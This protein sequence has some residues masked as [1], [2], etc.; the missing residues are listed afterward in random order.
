MAN[1]A[2]VPRVTP[3]DACAVD[4][5]PEKCPIVA[6]LA[7]RVGFK[8]DCGQRVAVSRTVEPVGANGTFPPG[9]VAA[10]S[11][12]A[13]RGV[14]EGSFVGAAWLAG[15]RAWGVAELA[16]GTRQALCQSFNRVGSSGAQS[17]ALGGRQAF[18]AAPR[19]RRAHAARGRTW[20]VA[21]LA[22]GAE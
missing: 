3:A 22:D 7:P 16:D 10:F 11:A 13:R 8:A 5:A 20:G 14:C 17:G 19:S 15:G 2:I 12:N 1:Q 4:W 9:A 6:A 21:E 18:G